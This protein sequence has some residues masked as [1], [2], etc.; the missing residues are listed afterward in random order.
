MGLRKHQGLLEIIGIS[1]VVLAGF[2]G[3]NYMIEEI[4]KRRDEIVER[5][6]EKTRDEIY[7][8]E[9]EKFKRDLDK[10]GREA[11]YL[12]LIDKDKNYRIEEGEIILDKEREGNYDFSDLEKKGTF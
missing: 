11:I 12:E 5:V 10:A 8:K 1:V 4:A 9:L 3:T 7:K 6:V 2:L